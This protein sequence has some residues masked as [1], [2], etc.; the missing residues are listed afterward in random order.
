MPESHKGKL[1]V[2]SKRS[3]KSQEADSGAK[4]LA[5]QFIV[6][7]FTKEYHLD[8]KKPAKIMNKI[9]AK[10]PIIL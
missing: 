1:E 2:R 8:R 6:T 7:I 4:E 10:T 5:E 9:E 3:F